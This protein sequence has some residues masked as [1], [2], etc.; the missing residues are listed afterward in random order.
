M[1]E[2]S[3]LKW[4]EFCVWMHILNYVNTISSA[5]DT[6]GHPCEFS[7]FQYWYS[8]HSSI[9]N[10]FS[11]RTLTNTFPRKANQQQHYTAKLSTA[12]VRGD[13]WSQMPRGQAQKKNLVCYLIQSLL[14]YIFNPYM[15]YP[16][17]LVS[18][19]RTFV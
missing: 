5:V 6:G 8:K 17:T 16:Q 1:A 2:L 19:S 15:L 11:K 10:W 12:L 14:N 3:P 7:G 18:S 13:C 9:V 4:W